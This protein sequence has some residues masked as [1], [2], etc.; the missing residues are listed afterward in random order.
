MAKKG[1]QEHDKEPQEP[2][3]KLSA[4]D[5]MLLQALGDGR[6]VGLADDPAA[7]LYPELWKCMTQTEGGKDYILQPAVVTLQFGPAGCIATLTHRDLKWTLSVSCPHIG[8]ALEV[9][10]AA[11]SSPNPPI[12]TW[13]KDPQVQLRK[14][15]QK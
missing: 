4:L 12:R 15:R 7:E 5:R 8:Q 6:T 1:D 9:L 2:Q 11:L 14:R 10:E 3:R 13:G